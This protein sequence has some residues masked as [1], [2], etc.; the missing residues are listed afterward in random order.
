[1]SIR[2]GVRLGIDVGTVRIGV[3]RTDPGGLLALPVETVHRA[4]DGSEIERIVAL[5]L[6]YAAFE[7]ILGLP[8]HLKGN[9]G[10]SAKA[11]RKYGKRLKKLLPKVRVALVDERLSSNQ[12]HDRLR[13]A[14]RS[15]RSHRDVV[16]QVAAQ[17]IL[18]HAL[19]MERIG[20]CPP[21]EELFGSDGKDNQ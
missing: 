15:E 6:E 14:G 19:E 17:I 20:A 10:V 1:M 2:P 12:A 16:D 4:P 8:R 7:I 5:A 13:A 9:E 3:A 18:E 21:G 11:A